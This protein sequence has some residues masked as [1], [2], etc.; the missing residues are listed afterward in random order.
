MQQSVLEQ[1]GK[2]ADVALIP[3]VVLT[4]IGWLPVAT[5]VLTFIWA[6]FRVYELKTIQ[7]WLRRRKK[8]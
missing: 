8:S 2:A 1:A 5:G 3:A 7:S 6:A 4:L